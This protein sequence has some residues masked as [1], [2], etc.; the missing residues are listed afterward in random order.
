MD[1][2]IWDEE[3]S[4]WIGH[5]FFTTLDLVFKYKQ[6]V[7]QVEFDD[8]VWKIPLLNYHPYK[9]HGTDMLNR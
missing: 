7:K 8:D 3:I 2:I 9:I 6:Q 4:I 1:V 5:W